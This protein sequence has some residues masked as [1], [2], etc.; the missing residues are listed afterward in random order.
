MSKS[1]AKVTIGPFEGEE[2]EQNIEDQLIDDL[3]DKADGLEDT[4]IEAVK[5][6]KR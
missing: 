2:D 6:E 5:A 4:D 1:K 3:A